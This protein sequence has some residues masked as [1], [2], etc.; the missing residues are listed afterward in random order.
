[1][2]SV[3][4]QVINTPVVEPD[5]HKVTVPWRN[6]FQT[7]NAA[8]SGGGGGGAITS[9]TGDVTAT[10]PGAA[11]ATIANT[12]VTPGSYGSATQVGTFTVNSQGRLTAAAN[13]AITANVTHTGTLTANQVV[14]GNG[15]A[16]I[17][18]LGTLG[19]TTTV[20][21]GNA[22]GAP[23]FAAVSL[24]A[25]VSG[26]LPFANLTPATAA[27]KVLGR[28]DSGAGD[29]QEISL[30]TGL[31]MSGTTLSA[32]GT[33]G[34]VTTTGSPASGN[35][36]KFSG[37]SSITN[38]DLSGDVTTS[39]TLVTTL[40]TAARTRGITFAIDGGGLVLTSGVK[41]DVYV[42]YAC[43][44]TAATMLADQTGSVTV[45]IKKCA[46]GSFPGSLASI[47]ASSAPAITAGN[48]KSQDTTLSSWTT[49]ISAGDVLEFEITGTPTSITRL[50]LT[51][52]VTV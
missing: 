21:H 38:G 32:T 25:D 45:D 7:L 14:I 8:S 17:K 1:M 16:D 23:T 48:Q 41:A 3:F 35:L 27:S 36:T 19:T 2:A 44:I 39:G 22:A 47:T 43:T 15:S 4:Y 11:A 52:T 31:S 13:V 6:F 18:T 37:S 51:L 20:L 40:K 50:N 33:G 46:Y 42:P 9:L 10:G 29:Y 12:A 30:G 28:G 24:S 26:D 49:S 5:S 34:T